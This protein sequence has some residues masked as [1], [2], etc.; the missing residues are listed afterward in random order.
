MSNDRRTCSLELPKMKKLPKDSESLARDFERYLTR[1]LGRFV[2]C[3]PYYLYEALTLTLR[4][5]IMTDWRNT[6]KSHEKK[7]L[8][9]RITCHLNF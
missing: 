2:G 7:V 8:E 3:P 6:W 4:D 1:H 5:R 9:K